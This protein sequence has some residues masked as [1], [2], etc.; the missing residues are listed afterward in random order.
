MCS[1]ADDKEKPRLLVYQTVSSC[2]G[3]LSKSISLL[4]SF[5][6]WR[7]LALCGARFHSFFCPHNSS[8]MNMNTA[9]GL[10]TESDS[11]YEQ[12][13]NSVI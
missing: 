7:A 4:S 9:S 1:E 13:N 2:M 5:Q 3:T 10:V 6:V 11:Y 12:D 8:Q